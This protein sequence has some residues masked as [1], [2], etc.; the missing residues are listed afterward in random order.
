MMEI[1]QKLPPELATKWKRLLAWQ[2]GD[3][4]VLA[5][6]A[7]EFLWKRYG[8]EVAQTERRDAAYRK[9]IA[10]TKRRLDAVMKDRG[11]CSLAEATLRKVGR[12]VGIA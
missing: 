10:D 8:K 1:K 3:A 5:L 6:E 2:D 7:V 11:G 12:N 4:E 9:K